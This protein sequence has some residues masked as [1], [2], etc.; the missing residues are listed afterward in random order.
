MNARAVR[1]EWLLKERLRTKENHASY[2]RSLIHFNYMYGI[3]S[4]LMM[5]VFEDWIFIPAPDPQGLGSSLEVRDWDT[6][7]TIGLIFLLI[8]GFMAILSFGSAFYLKTLKNYFFVFLVA[9]TQCF[10]FPFGLILGVS[11]I[12]LLLKPEVSSLWGEE[13]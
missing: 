3:L 8:S 4:A 11:T 9:I 6:G 1:Q 7:K 12:N 5:L 13:L 2:F 10:F